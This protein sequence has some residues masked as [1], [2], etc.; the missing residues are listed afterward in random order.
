MSFRT[1][2]PFFS[3]RSF[4]LKGCSD[5]VFYPVTS[6][7]VLRGAKQEF[8]PQVNASFQLPGYVVAG[9]QLLLIQP[10]SYSLRLQCVMQTD[11][12]GFVQAAIAY[13]TRKELDT[14]PD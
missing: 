8:V 10:A 12:E 1:G 14:M 11:S 4:F 2:F 13:E 6:Q 3:E 5:L 9:K 7:R